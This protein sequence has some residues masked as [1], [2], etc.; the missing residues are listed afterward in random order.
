MPATFQVDDTDLAREQLV[1]NHA[2]TV[3]DGVVVV[4][5]LSD[6][7]TMRLARHTHT[8]THTHTRTHARTG[9]GFQCAALRA[10]SSS[11]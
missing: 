10:I 7:D 8:H 1:H 6:V 2:E 11:S 4:V 9:V 5:T 3:A